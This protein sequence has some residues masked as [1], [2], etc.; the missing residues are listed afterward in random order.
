MAEKRLGVFALRKASVGE[1]S[2]LYSFLL[3]DNEEIFLE[4]KA[5]RDVLIFT[6]ERIIAVNVQGLTGKKKEYLVIPYSKIAAFSLESA[7]TLDLDAECKIYASGLGCIEFGFLK[8]TNIKE[9]VAF[10]GEKIK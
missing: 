6:S 3:L 1:S 8:G 7:G 5:I 4:Y 10:L 9:V 2:E